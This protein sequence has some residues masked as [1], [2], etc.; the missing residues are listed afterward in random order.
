MQLDDL[1]TFIEG[2]EAGQISQDLLAGKPV[3][4]VAPVK[5]KPGKCKF[6]GSSHKWGR[7]FC[8]AS[9][10][11][12][13]SCKKEGHFEAVCRSKKKEKKEEKSDGDAAKPEDGTKE[14]ISGSWADAATEINI[15]MNNDFNKSFI[16]YPPSS[17]SHP[18]LQYSL[19][20]S[21]AEFKGRRNKKISPLVQFRNIRE[22]FLFCAKLCHI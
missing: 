4:P 21:L 3:A 19:N 2:K 12:C 5:S 6:C 20:Q 15:D 9:Q 22:T 14:Q 18:I 11:T 17:Y 8:K 10:H 13:T 7:A 16:C 1:L